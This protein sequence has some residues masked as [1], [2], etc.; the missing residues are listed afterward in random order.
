MD[1][2]IIHHKSVNEKLA[3]EIAL[4]KRFKFTKLCEQLSLDQASLIE[5]LIDTDIAAIE[6]ELEALQ[7]APAE[8]SAPAAQ[9]RTAA[10]AVS[11]HTHL[12][13]T[14]KQPLPVRLRSQA[15]RRRYQ[16]KTR[17]HARRIHRRAPYPWK[18]GL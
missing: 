8:V 15:H 11:S 2:Q 14:G 12:S 16:R 4:L 1:N 13:R 3:H 18:M 9:A 17:L 7:S 6:A 10:I 5:D